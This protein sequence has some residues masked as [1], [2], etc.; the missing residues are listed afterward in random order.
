MINDKELFITFD[1][2]KTIH[3]NTSL[4]LGW[5]KDF[6]DFEILKYNRDTNVGLLYSQDKY[7]SISKY[8]NSK[9]ENLVQY[10]FRC[11]SKI[12]RQKQSRFIR[13]SN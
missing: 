9:F 7:L 13:I 4:F 6:Y 3:F 5:K 10:K 11:I 2:N 12:M 8:N 1:R